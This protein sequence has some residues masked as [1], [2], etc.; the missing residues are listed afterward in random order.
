M[1][2][3]D[4][5]GFYYEFE[6]EKDFIPREMDLT[7]TR[8][9]WASQHA[10]KELG[11]FINHNILKINR[12][13]FLDRVAIK[14]EDLEQLKEVKN[15]CRYMVESD[16]LLKLTQ[17]YILRNFNIELFQ[18][19]IASTYKFYKMQDEIISKDEEVKKRPKI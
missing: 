1:K 16:N 10:T 15:F 6:L 12:D 11:G 19:G 5:E 14:T 2:F 9:Q 8:K 18:K 4:N 17:K 13:G 3:K 7:F